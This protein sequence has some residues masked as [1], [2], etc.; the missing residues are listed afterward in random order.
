MKYVVVLISALL[1]HD[2]T[3]LAQ[4]EAGAVAEPTPDGEAVTQPPE[5]EAKKRSVYYRKARGWLWIEGLV[6]VSAYDPDSFGSLSAAAIENAP[7][8]TGPEYG[9]AFGTPFGGPFFLGFFYR[10]ASY[11]E[12]KLLKKGLDMQG[13]I[14]IPYVH[15]ILRGSIGYARTFQGNPYGLENVDNRGVAFTGG[16]GVRIPI[17]R[18]ISLASTFD[19]TYIALS[20]RGDNPIDGS[21]VHSWI[22]GQ[23]FGLTFALTF[24]FIGVRRD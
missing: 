22:N 23:Q 10:Q 15:I 17:I 1:L 13:S 20:M 19:W 4:E 3:A 12:Y 14:M 6:G 18:W 7:R 2:T 9:F 16:F 11:G 24:Q 21:S 5:P 8:V